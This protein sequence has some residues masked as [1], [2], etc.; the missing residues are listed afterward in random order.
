MLSNDIKDLEDFRAK[1]QRLLKLWVGRL[2]FYS[3]ALYLLTCLFVY[4]LYFPEQWSARLITA[5]PLLAFPAL[6]L[7]VRKLLIFLFSKRTERNSKHIC[8]VVFLHSSRFSSFSSSY[9][10]LLC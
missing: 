10:S 3:S 5:L 8:Y 2:L 1:N 6:V 9:C 4:Y 7:L